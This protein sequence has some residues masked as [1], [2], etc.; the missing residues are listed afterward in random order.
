MRMVKSTIVAVVLL[1]MV[2]SMS[3][4]AD[5]AG[6]LW[7]LLDDSSVILHDSMNDINSFVNGQLSQSRFQSNMGRYMNTAHRILVDAVLLEPDHNIDDELL[8][9]SVFIISNFYLIYNLMYNA[10]DTMDVGMID[11]A[12]YVMQ[13]NNSYMDILINR[14][15]SRQ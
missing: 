8:A 1:V 14:I 11:A 7:R 10:L 15:E 6:D 12:T 3:V 4:Q 13:F 9:D 5:T 2:F